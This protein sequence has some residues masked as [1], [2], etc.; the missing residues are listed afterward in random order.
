MDPD[1]KALKADLHLAITGGFAPATGR[2]AAIRLDEMIGVPIA[3]EIRDFEDGFAIRR[4]A[5]IRFSPHTRSEVKKALYHL[6][7]SGLVEWRGILWQLAPG[8]QCDPQ[9][10]YFDMAVMEIELRAIGTHDSRRKLTTRPGLKVIGG[11]R[12]IYRRIAA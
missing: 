5:M 11:H 9:E 3:V 8:Y 6:A 10:S 2:K 7:Y 4:E 1:N 12:D